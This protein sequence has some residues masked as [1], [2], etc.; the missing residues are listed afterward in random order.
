MLLLYVHGQIPK[1]NF[2]HA[3]AAP[4]LITRY[5]DPGQATSHTVHFCRCIS[6]HSLMRDLMFASKHMLLRLPS[7]LMSSC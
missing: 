5:I 3:A 7:M 4:H 2:A 1:L 6:R